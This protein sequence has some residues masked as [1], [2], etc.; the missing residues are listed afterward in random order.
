MILP[1][2]RSFWWTER[3][4]VESRGW[5]FISSCFCSTFDFEILDT[6]AS[7]FTLLFS[8]SPLWSSHSVG[9]ILVS[10]MIDVVESFLPVDG[11][12]SI[13]HFNRHYI[14]KNFCVNNYMK[15]N[16]NK[17]SLFGIL[18]MPNFA[19]T[20]SADNS[21]GDDTP[22]QAILDSNVFHWNMI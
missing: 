19:S 4:I 9:T 13:N 20:S 11:S 1:G 10:G 14:S 17:F 22:Q 18:P 7:V 21:W 2:G 6:S 16:T 15:W 8:F 3:W 5:I 12:I